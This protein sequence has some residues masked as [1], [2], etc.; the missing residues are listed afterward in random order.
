MPIERQ[1]ARK[2]AVATAQ[3]ERSSWSFGQPRIKSEDR[4]FFTERLA[5]LLETGSPLHTALE[6]LERQAD[7]EHVRHMIHQ[8]LTNV[9]GGL[10]F[11]QALAKQP[12]AFPTTY[13]NLIAAA[14]TGGFLPQVLQRLQEMDEKRRELNSALWAAL[15]YP[16]FL[17][18]FSFAVVVF[19]L[20]VVFP[21]FSVLFASIADELPPTT[22]LLML[23]SDALRR[24]WLPAAVALGAS[25]TLVW[26]WGKRPE[27]A[28][29]LDRLL[30]RVPLL[31]EIVIELQLVQFMSVMSLSLTNGVTVL[32]AL[33][34]CREIVRSVSFQRFVS[35]LETHINEGGALSP[36]FAETEF[37]PALV[38]QMIATGEQTGNLAM[39]MGRISE[40]Y[41]REWKKRLTVF[42]KIAEPAML[43]LMGTVVGVIVA[44]LILPIFKL[45]RGVH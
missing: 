5:L 14:E 45:S 18:C 1:I 39:V 41:E 42:A 16:A 23:L 43:L 26:R 44:S 38:P 31:G 40:F 2:P 9:S 15:S 35:R 11:A 12:D 4:M 22:Q 8:L 32:D 25:A 13:V 33:R 17:M 6:T 10:T 28:L 7:Q 24:Y 19:M 21:K 36:V 27:G 30:R 3:H 29:A 37:L 34:S 20:T